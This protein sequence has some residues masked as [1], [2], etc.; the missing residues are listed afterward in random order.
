MEEYTLPSNSEGK[1]SEKGSTFSALAFPVNDVAEVKAK[2]IQLKEQ[3]PDAI[4]I[5]YG[6]RIREG[7]RL[8][9]FATDAGEPKGSSGLPILN[10]LKRN[11][12]VDAVI[13]VVRYFGGIKLGI[14]GLINA[15]G[16]AAKEA[17]ANANFNKWVQLVRISFK[18]KYGLQKKV[19]SVLRKNNV[20]IINSKFGESIQVEIEIEVEKTEA[21][22]KELSEI[23]NG[24]I[25][26]K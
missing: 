22:G 19:E 5:C 20:T 12:I 8:D 13:F 10:A 7:G 24:L 3:F 6:Y 23:S 21:L 9:E 15:Y 18:Y 14:S 11:Q 25:T 1:Y 16:S 26:V 17:L 4:H 2:L